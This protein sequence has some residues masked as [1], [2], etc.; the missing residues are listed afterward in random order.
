MNRKIV[1]GLF[2]AV[3]EMS[4]MA[5]SIQAQQHLSVPRSDGQWTPLLVYPAKGATSKCAPLAVISHG[6]GGSE[7][8]YRYLGETLSRL[9][10]TAVVMGHHESGLSELSA[11]ILKHGLMPGIRALVTDTD[12]EEARLLDV[13]AALKWADS[14]CK[15]PFRVLLGHSMGAETVMLEAGAKN[16]IGVQAPPAGQD[17]FDAYVALSPEGPGVVFPEDAW[18]GIHKPVLILTGTKDQALQGEP[19]ERQFPWHVLPNRTDNCNWMGVIDGATHMNF[20]DY[21]LDKDRVEQLVAQTIK[22]FLNGVNKNSC[23]VPA[24]TAGMALQ[25]K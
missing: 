2:V 11:D 17:R 16:I 10:Y 22:K 21:G 25:T 19:E 6:A 8:G 14:Q 18:C 13:G 15:A 7:N 12:A 4:M 24:A 3:F 1:R 5:L 23:V 9:G 20:A